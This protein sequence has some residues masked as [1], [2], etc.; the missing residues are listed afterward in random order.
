MHNIWNSEQVWRIVSS[1]RKGFCQ[2][3]KISTISS[4][5]TY[6]RVSP[7]IASPVPKTFFAELYEQV[8]PWSRG[9]LSRVVRQLFQRQSTRFENRVEKVK[10]AEP[11]LTRSK[12]H[13]LSLLLESCRCPGIMK[14]NIN[15]KECLFASIFLR[16]RQ[17]ALKH[18]AKQQKSTLQ[19]AWLQTCELLFTSLI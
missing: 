14:R 8:R 15:Q 18:L 6:E 4:E 5:S 1:S 19:V 11:S 12:L 17:F 7:L 16:L 2:W 13:W 3:G 10:P 9:G